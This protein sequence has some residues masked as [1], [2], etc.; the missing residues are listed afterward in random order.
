[1]YDKF[2]VMEIFGR[3]RKELTSGWWNC[4]SLFSRIRLFYV[5]DLKRKAQ[6]SR[7]LEMANLQMYKLTAHETLI[8]NLLAFASKARN[9]TITHADL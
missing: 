3:P 5:Q 2:I 6:S 4:S 7:S 8:A 1:M 9:H